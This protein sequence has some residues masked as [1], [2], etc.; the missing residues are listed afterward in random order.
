MH[1]VVGAGCY[2]LW[3]GRAHASRGSHG[4]KDYL[5]WLGGSAT[6]DGGAGMLQALGARVVDDQGCDVAPVLRT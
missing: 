5:Y 6:N 3:R 2:N 1:G 4:R